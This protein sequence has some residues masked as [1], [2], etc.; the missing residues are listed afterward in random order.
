MSR[1]QRVY[2]QHGGG[3]GHLGRP[4]L[5]LGAGDG[6]QAAEVRLDPGLEFA[7]QRKQ[8]GAD[9]VSQKSGVGVGGVLAPGHLVVAEVATDRVAI[10]IEERTD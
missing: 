2:I 4:V 8:S 5:F 7:E 10:E 6:G 1:L 9:A 3:G